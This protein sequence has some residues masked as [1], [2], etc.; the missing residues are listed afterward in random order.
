MAFGFTRELPSVIGHNYPLGRLAV[1]YV[2]EGAAQR[3]THRVVLPYDV[4]LQNAPHD[5]GYVATGA[6]D[7]I[8]VGYEQRMTMLVYKAA[9]LE[10]VGLFDIGPQSQTPIFDGPPELIVSKHGAAYDLFLPQYTGNATTVLTWKPND[11]LWLAAPTDLSATRLEK[12]VELSW[13]SAT[14]SIGWQIERRTLEPTGWSA[15]K[16]AGATKTSVSNWRDPAPPGSACAYRLRALGVEQS[17]SDW[18]KT[19]YLR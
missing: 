18:S 7:Y 8:F 11:K 16:K 15:W 1:R 17:A 4:N 3:E 14:N 12:T 9:T 5:Q 2:I 10:L 19:R 6:G 13:K